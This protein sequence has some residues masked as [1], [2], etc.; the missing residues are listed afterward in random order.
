MIERHFFG[1]EMEL[2]EQVGNRR[3]DALHGYH[4]H[5]PLTPEGH[6]DS[7]AFLDHAD[8]FKVARWRR[9]ESK[10]HG[11]ILR[12]GSGRWTFRYDGAG[13][14]ADETSFRLSEARFAP[15]R[16]LSVTEDDGVTRAFKVISV[17]PD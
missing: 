4:L 2:A 13:D 17:T 6:I 14:I 8:A 11:Q 7:S 12:G 15:G 1:I 10:Q 9:G 5:L 16:F 3:D